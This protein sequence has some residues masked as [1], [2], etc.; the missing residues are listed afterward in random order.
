MTKRADHIMEISKEE[1]P[2]QFAEIFQYGKEITRKT[3]ISKITPEAKSEIEPAKGNLKEIQAKTKYY[4]V[5]HP[6]FTDKPVWSAVYDE[7]TAN[8]FV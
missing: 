8:I 1:V 7:K 3:F 5:L 6:N 2:A 4:K